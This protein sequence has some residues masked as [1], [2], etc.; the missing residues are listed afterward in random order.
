MATK[1]KCICGE[2]GT[3]LAFSNDLGQVDHCRSILV[4]NN[5]VYQCRSKPESAQEMHPKGHKYEIGETVWVQWIDHVW[6][7]AQVFSRMIIILE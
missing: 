4:Q 7:T 1:S 2:Y 5:G 6:Y 3:P